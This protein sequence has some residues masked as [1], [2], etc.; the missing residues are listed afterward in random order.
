MNSYSK[1]TQFFRYYL[2]I[3]LFF[4]LSVLA[5][6]YN[7]EKRYKA[8]MLDT[9]LGDSNKAIFSFLQSENGS[10]TRL[11]SLIRNSI[12]S[13]ERITV[14]DLTGKVVY[15]NEY[16]DINKMENHLTRKEVA[17]ASRKGSGSD[18]RISHTNH[19]QYYYHATRF[20]NCYVRSSLP[21]NLTVSLLS[22][23]NLFLY[24]W[25]LVTFIVVAALFYFSNRFA[26]QMQ[27]D[28][29][30]HDASVRRKLTQQVAHELKTPISS[31]IGY[32]ETLHNN[33]DISDE[34]RQFFIN[35]SYSQAVRL[36]QL[37][38]DILV[39]NQINEAPNTIKMEPVHL[40]SVIENVL[41][42]VE[43]NIQEKKI[44]VDTSF[45]GEIWL[46]GN[47]MLVYSI[48]RNLIDN[49]IAYA[50]EDVRINITLT[51]EDARLYYFSYSDNG[52]GVEA[53]HLPHLFDRFYRVDSGR[54]RKTG[55]SGLGLSIV[56]N[57][58]EIHRG[59]IS[60]QNKHTGGL[61][62]IFSLHK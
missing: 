21:Y 16:R 28:Q 47:Q 40:N 59:T 61:E 30:D 8:D 13:D 17:E 14:I 15:D 23:D 2:P 41:R 51:G 24:F 45:G 53:E 29:L 25:L 42:D 31:I 48:F 3:F 33:P 35:R 38:Q 49:T 9:E 19:K 50:G 12:Y 5:F 34:R 55:G 18:I 22:P 7:R 10:L 44:T 52:K 36:N 20:G 62:F 37:L 6:Q 26:I 4:S 1:K 58:V 46:K 11:D 54:S 60:V 39:L 56:K 43:F 27:R 57:A 32:M